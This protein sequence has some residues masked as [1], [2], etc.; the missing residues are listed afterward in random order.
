MFTP[1]TLSGYLDFCILDAVFPNDVI[2]RDREKLFPSNLWRN[3]S[4]AAALSYL[5]SYPFLALVSD[6]SPEM[7]LLPC[8][9]T[10]MF[11]VRSRIFQFLV[12]NSIYTFTGL[13]VFLCALF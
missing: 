4:A 2:W 7:E 11:S 1:L 9:W 12:A 10:D 13:K 6:M 8:C 3:E 5:T